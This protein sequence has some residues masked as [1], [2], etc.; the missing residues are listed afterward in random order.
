[1]SCRQQSST[2]SFIG[3]EVERIMT[4]MFETNTMASVMTI[5]QMDSTG[6]LK[7]TRKMKKKRSEGRWL[8]HLE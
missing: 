4:F 6:V 7:K 3:A 1:M 8:L 2:R 5:P